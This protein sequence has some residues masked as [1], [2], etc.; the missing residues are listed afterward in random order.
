MINRQRLADTFKWLAAVDSVSLEESVRYG[1]R[2][3]R[4]ACRERG[5]GL[6]I[7]PCDSTSPDLAQEL[8][9]L[10]ERNRLAGLVLAPPMSEQAELI[11]TLSENGISFV[12]IISSSSW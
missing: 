4:A 6:L 11:A 9:A 3:E 10:V 12:R 8:C 1:S 2:V 5:F 7:H